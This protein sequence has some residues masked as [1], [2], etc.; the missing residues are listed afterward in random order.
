MGLRLKYFVVFL[1]V[2]AGMLL[3]F[4]ATTQ[5]LLDTAFTELE[6]QRI[7]ENFS[8][9]EYLIKD[10]L[11]S[12]SKQVGDWAGWDESCEFIENGNTAFIR[13][14]LPDKT[15]AEL[16]INLIMF[17]HSSGR[18][19]FERW[20]NQLEAK[21]ASPRAFEKHVTASSRLLNQAY[22]ASSESGIINLPDGPILVAARPIVTTERSGPVRGTLI[23]GR[24]LD[25]IEIQ[26]LAQA[27]HVSFSI[28]PVGAPHVPPDLVAAQKSL[29][30]GT[31][32]VIQRLESEEL[33]GYGLVN[34][35]YGTP[36]FLLKTSIKSQRSDSRL[37]TL[38]ALLFAAGGV[39]LALAN[40]LFLERTVFAR[41]AAVS[42]TP[43]ENHGGDP[44]V[45]PPS[46]P[47]ADDI[48]TL[49]AMLTHLAAAMPRPDDA[50]SKEQARHYRN[51]FNDALTGNYVALPSGRIVLCNAALAQRLGFPSAKEILTSEENEL[52][53]D[54]RELSALVREARSAGV[55]QARTVIMRRHDGEETETVQHL[56]G[57]FDRNGE[58]T[59]LEGYLLPEAETIEAEADEE[60]DHP[61]A[62]LG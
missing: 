45:T 61:A 58:L 40:L 34:D 46:P 35:L 42:R 7:R 25:D 5:K 57:V 48:D 10:D 56:V 27:A 36:S 49:S 28:T 20:Y 50:A 18:I 22:A 54:P 62:A 53:A 13:R 2:L 44:V 29:Q 47:G 17:V 38:F 12:L 9:V 31:K 23:M 60:P 43:L 16:Q 1:A 37:L 26:R 51:F 8:R 52:F 32:F 55:L 41:L 4:F 33:A 14:N 21:E 24:N 19:V 39:T 15:F 3:I 30:K 11:T 6:H 59:C